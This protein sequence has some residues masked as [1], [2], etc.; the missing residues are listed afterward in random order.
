MQSHLI[1]TGKDAIPLEKVPEELSLVGFCRDKKSG[2]LN[3]EYDRVC[4]LH[5]DVYS[6]LHA[7]VLNHEKI[8]TSEYAHFSEEVYSL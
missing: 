3:K 5:S 8:K 7:S 4:S 2:Q 1:K 6:F